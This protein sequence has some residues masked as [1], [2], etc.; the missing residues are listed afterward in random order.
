MLSED[1]WEQEKCRQ[2]GR[3]AVVRLS[4]AFSVVSPLTSFVAIEERGDQEERALSR[5]E[6][7]EVVSSCLEAEACDVLPYMSWE[8][9]SGVVPG[10]FDRKD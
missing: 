5:E 10:A 8:E 2:D 7:G 6:F 4:K 3:T 1:P 9:A